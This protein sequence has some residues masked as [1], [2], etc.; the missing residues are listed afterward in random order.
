MLPYPP[1]ELDVDV[2]GRSLLIPL[3]GEALDGYSFLVDGRR[4]AL[5]GPGA[6]L[7]MRC[8]RLDVF[9]GLFGGNS[10]SMS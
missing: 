10:G 1:L 9:F 8:R 6:I 7:S 5:K 4:P 3:S 2:P